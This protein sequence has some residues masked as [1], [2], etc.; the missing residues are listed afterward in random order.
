MKRT[1]VIAPP[2]VPVFILTR[3]LD[4]PRALVWKS[5][6]DPV[7]LAQWWGPEG[8]TNKIHALDVRVGGEW[9]IDNITPDGQAFSFWGTVVEMRE[10]ERLA[11]TFHFLEYPSNLDV[12]V[13]EDLGDQTR[14]TSTTVLVSIEARTGMMESGM[15]GGAQGGFDRLQRLLD[16]MKVS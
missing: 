11:Q 8:F 16:G 6:V 7:L 13:L 3:V 4:A 9:R 10:G 5:L 14:I 12:M 15:E 1:P 2:E